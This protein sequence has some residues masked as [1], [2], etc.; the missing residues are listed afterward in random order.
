MGMMDLAGLFGGALQGYAQQ[1]QQQQYAYTASGTAN[2]VNYVVSMSPV[3]AVQLRTPG[4][5]TALEWL[6]R[7]VREVRLP[8]AA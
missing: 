4:P 8:L 2:A 7:R 5:E 1:Q 6:D 3:D